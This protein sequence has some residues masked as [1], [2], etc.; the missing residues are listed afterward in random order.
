MPGHTKN[1]TFR[2]LIVVD[3]SPLTALDILDILDVLPVVA[4]DIWMKR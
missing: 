2:T 3:S 4:D 1:P